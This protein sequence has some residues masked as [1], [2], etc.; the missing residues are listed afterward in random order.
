MNKFVLIGLAV[1]VGLA[2]LLSP[3]AS[4]SPDGLEKVAEIKSFF[5]KSEGKNVLNTLIP[6][7]L[8][9]GIKNERIATAAAGGF[10]TLLVFITIYGIGLLLKK[11]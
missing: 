6:D 11:K 9:P 4:P 10:G 8:F 1:A 5:Y 3:F 2:I 7:Y